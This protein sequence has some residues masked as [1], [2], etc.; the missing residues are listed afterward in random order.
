MPEHWYRYEDRLY[1]RGEGEPSELRVTLRMYEVIKTTPKGVWLMSFGPNRFV[2]K[3][4]RKRF[5]CPTIEEAKASFIARKKR[6]ISIYTARVHQAEH[7]VRKIE[8]NNWL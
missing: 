7:A 3:D 2:L 1:S 8:T 6:Q 5:A 4:A